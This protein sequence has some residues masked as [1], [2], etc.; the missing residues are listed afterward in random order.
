MSTPYLV[1]D[2]KGSKRLVLPGTDFHGRIENED[3]LRPLN[4]CSILSVPSI[5]HDNTPN[6]YGSSL[7][8][9]PYGKGPWLL[10]SYHS[11][12]VE[13]AQAFLDLPHCKDRELTHYRISA[14][15]DLD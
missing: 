14:S 5:V 4:Y 13:A 6:Q 2:A 3:P 7:D 15:P 1:K 8:W 9:S 10:V 12:V 11:Y